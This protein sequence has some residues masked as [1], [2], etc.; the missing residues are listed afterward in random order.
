MHNKGHGELHNVLYAAMYLLVCY[1]L[2]CLD[3]ENQKLSQMKD[4]IEV[5]KKFSLPS[6]FVYSG[7]AA[8]LSMHSALAG[9]CRLD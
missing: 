1:R 4:A 2:T 9:R 5:S 7:S 6:V 3:G 8:W